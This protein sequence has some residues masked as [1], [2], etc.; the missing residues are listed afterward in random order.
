MRTSVLLFIASAF[1]GVQWQLW[2]GGFLFMLPPLLA[3]FK[4]NFPNSTPLFRVLPR[5]IVKLVIMLVLGVG[6]ASMV[7]RGVQQSA[8]PALNAFVLLAVPGVIVSLLE[9]FGREGAPPREG[10]GRWLL[11]AAILGTGVWLVL[12]VLR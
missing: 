4:G 2:V 1:L 9:L 6:I 10:W 7:T 12:V 5:G 3:V 8:Q 11:G